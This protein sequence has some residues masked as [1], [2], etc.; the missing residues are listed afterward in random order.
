M[1]IPNAV[2]IVPTKKTDYIAGINS[3]IEYKEVLPSGNWEKYLSTEER[4]RFKFLETMACVSFSFLN[5]VETQ[6]NRFIMEGLLPLETM[7]F[8]NDS[9]YIDEN[10]KFNGS[11]RCLAKLSNTT[12]KGNSLENV[13][14]IGRHSGILPEKDWTWKEDFNW[15]SYYSPIPQNLIDK[16]KRFLDYFEIQ[17]EKIIW[18]LSATKE[19]LQK[20]L[21]QS[22]IQ[23]A[24][25]VCSGWS[26]DIPVKNC[27]LPV[28]HASILYNIDQYK[29]DFDSYAPYKK[30]L[31]MN[32]YI[33]YTMKILLIPKTTS[34]EYIIVGKEQFLVDRSLKLAFNIG[35]ESELIKLKKNGLKGEPVVGN[36]DGLT[37]YPLV[38]SSRLKDLFGL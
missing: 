21:K 17:Y 29:R 37:V 3:K 19:Q 11:D 36:I 26:T 1:K 15:N 24:S 22:P 23:I 38:Q 32:Y 12:N 28:S 6:M 31:A 7:T 2:I 5:S 9:G 33:P 30:A 34:M 25:Q 27:N 18:G 13:C 14:D 8:L 35:D 4:Q 16:S 10:G 20:H